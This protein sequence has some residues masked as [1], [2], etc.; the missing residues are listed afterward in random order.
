VS[1]C[2]QALPSLQGAPSLALGETQAPVVASQTPARW[3][4]STGPGQV[5][6]VPPHVPLPSHASPVVHLTPSSHAVPAGFDAP[7]EHR[8][9]LVSQVPAEEQAAVPEHWTGLVPVQTPP[10]QVSV[11]VQ[12]LLSL[13][14]APSGTTV[15]AGQVPV[16]SEHVPAAWQASAGGGQIIWVPPHVP[17]P[18]H[19]SPVVHLRPS[20]HAAPAGLGAPPVHVPLLGSQVPADVQAEA[21][22]H[23]TGLAPTHLPAW[24]VSVCVQAL[25]SLQ[26]PPSAA[27]VWTHLPSDPQAS[28]VQ[29]SPSSQ[30]IGI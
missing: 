23:W 5:N 9:V 17:L 30:L 10:W 12:A 1:V 26:P 6:G 2:V 21:P 16:V 4:A 18:S 29:G 3:Q 25:P 15:G 8:P 27:G 14:A 7:P 11:F 28:A 20:S 13:Q 24:Q 22:E 19:A